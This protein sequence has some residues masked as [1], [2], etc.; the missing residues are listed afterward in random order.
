MKRLWR[1]RAFCLYWLGLFLSGVGD[2]FGWMALTWYVMRKTGSSVAMGGMILAYLLPGLLAGLVIGVL[3][4]RFDRRMLVIGDNVARGALFLLLAYLLGN[5]Q[6]PAWLVYAV[7]VTAGA[8]SPLSTSGVQAMLPQLV[9]D[10]T[11]L[12]RAN[13]LM[14]TQWQ[15][16]FLFGPALAGVLVASFGELT[17]LLLDAMSFFLC[18]ACFAALPG[19]RGRAIGPAVADTVSVWLHRLVMDMKAGFAYVLQRPPLVWLVLVTFFFNLSYGPVEVA[20]PLYA[21]NE[22]HGGTA[23]LG[24]LWTALA[25]GS[26]AGSLLFSLVNWSWPRGGTLAAIIV[27]WGVCTLPLA[28]LP[29]TGVAIAAICLAGLVFSPYQVL[30]MSG[31]QADVP[32]AVIGRVLTSVRAVTGLGMPLGAFLSGLLIPVIGVRGLLAVSAVAC[33]IVGAAAFRLLRPVR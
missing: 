9:T 18:A 27:L 20:L 26:L 14:Q 31:L 19:W 8:L 4:D 6:S 23:L 7:V 30:Y 11:L 10:K 22:L 21:A 12:I 28:V 25:L 33:I 24:T 16:V 2:Q 29:H 32:A 17:V 5:E 1:N 3:L 15:I 13:A